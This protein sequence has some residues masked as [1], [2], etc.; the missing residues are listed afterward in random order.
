MIDTL[1][2]WQDSTAIAGGNTF[3]IAPYLSDV[4][5]RQS[6]TKGYS[7]SGNVL[8]YTV[9]VFERGVSL[10]GSLC[11]FLF[12]DNLQTLTRRT[13]GQAIEKL[14][15]C[16]HLDISTAK[17]TRFDISTV[18]P[19]KRPPADYYA[20]LGQKPFFTRLQSNE[21]SL[22]YNNHQRQIIFYDKTK[23][24]KA[25]GMPIPDI[26]KGCNLFRYEL[27]YTKGINRQFKADVTAAMLYDR[28]FY[29]TIIQNWY[30]EFKDI[31][32]IKS[33]S[34]MIDDI[35]NRKDAK[36]ALF[37]FLLNE[38]GQ[39]LVTDYLRELKANNAFKSRSDYTKLKT[40]L[41]KMLVAKNG[42]KNDLTKELEIA[43]FDIAKDAR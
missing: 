42:N 2:L 22:Y 25:K 31:Q 37:S 21:D 1:N 34:F 39:N 13:V 40:D 3:A 28:A 6:E 27:R 26:W 19:T 10:N 33:N 17:A 29:D 4:T 12:G 43:F 14:S 9:H 41:N 20:Y 18:T 35:D 15:D 16:L 5:E 30:K 23:E 24:A 36:E 38:A 7:I 11:K 32:K 8:D